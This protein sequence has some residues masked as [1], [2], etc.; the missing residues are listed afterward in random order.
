M[1]VL[2]EMRDEVVV[3]GFRRR[4]GSGG[5]LANSLHPTIPLPMLLMSRRQT[6]ELRVCLPGAVMPYNNRVGAI[7]LV[8][9]AVLNSM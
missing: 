4:S 7:L 9:M 6:R 8:M 3:T 2:L 5:G 1:E